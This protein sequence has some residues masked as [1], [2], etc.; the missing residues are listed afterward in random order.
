[1]KLSNT[2]GYL[3]ANPWNQF[4]VVM[5]E[6]LTYIGSKILEV[7]FV[8]YSSWVYAGY[9]A[10]LEHELCSVTEIRNTANLYSTNNNDLFKFQNIFLE[11]T[12]IFNIG[13]A[14]MFIGWF[15]S[16]VE[17]CGPLFLFLITFIEYFYH[18]WHVSWWK[19]KRTW[20]NKMMIKLNETLSTP[21][22]SRT[23]I[24]TR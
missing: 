19:N 7:E 23:H 22:L 6:V 20:H 24:V 15:Y 8:G 4:W 21:I 1:M 14:W 11:T 10:F 18:T 5:V 13:I 9:M 2:S 3:E 16:S 17:S 12:G